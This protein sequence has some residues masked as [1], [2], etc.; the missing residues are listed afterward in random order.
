MEAAV[1][2]CPY[3]PPLNV[4]MDGKMGESFAVVANLK[5]VVHETGGS[6]GFQVDQMGLPARVKE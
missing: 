6:N 2:Y 1:L 5:A 4:R 3:V